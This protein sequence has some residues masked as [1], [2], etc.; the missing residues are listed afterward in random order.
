MRLD[1]IAT[2]RFFYTVLG[3]WEHGS[4]R[5]LRRSCNLCLLQLA[6]AAEKTSQKLSRC[7]RSRQT[8]TANIHL[9]STSFGGSC[10]KANWKDIYLVE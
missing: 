4:S 9:P 2:S 6:M 7:D 8:C 3:P 1:D 5:L 10:M